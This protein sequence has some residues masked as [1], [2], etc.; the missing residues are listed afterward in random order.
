MMRA[1]RRAS[2]LW[3]LAL[4]AG[5]GASGGGA[6]DLSADLS[7]TAIN[8]TG[9]VASRLDFDL[10]LGDA[11]AGAPSSMTVLGLWNADQLSTPSP[12]GG[13]EVDSHWQLCQL[14]LPDGVDAPFDD[15]GLA[16]VNAYP[17]NGSLAGTADGSRFTQGLFAIV[18]GA[19]L[20]TPTT[21][22]LPDASAPVCG[23]SVST[24]CLV[25]N[26]V[27]TNVPGIHVTATGLTPDADELYIDFR[28]D[29][30]FSATASFDFTVDGMVDQASLD[31][32]VLSCHLR[33]GSPCTP[34]D[35][36]AL[37]ANKPP[38][39][40]T[41]GTVKS[42]QQGFYFDCP[43][44]LADPVGAVT[45]NELPLDGS[46]PDGATA[47][48]SVSFADVEQDMDAQGCATCHE[49]I[50]GANK[51]HLTFRPWTVDLLQQ[52]YQ[53]VLP[54]TAASTMGG[55]AGGRFVNQTP[56]PAPMRDR[57]LAWIA[58]GAPY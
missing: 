6:H 5:C 43:E 46:A 52:N 7:V 44:F 24:G 49:A 47:T 38:L 53:A 29:L 25:P 27:S 54:W 45:G 34:A 15:A 16:Y 28:L 4:A 14:T 1:M 13:L 9:K 2:L 40:I 20:H 8:L 37:E 33:A 21:D 18:G 3:C 17:T 41:S 39:H 19:A 42:H 22:P 36:A 30:A 50:D 48:A 56:I 57:W 11:D 10:R 55:L 31:W 58:A 12:S 23:P 26:H 35:I 32:H 51:L